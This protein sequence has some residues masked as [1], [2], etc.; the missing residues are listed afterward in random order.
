MIFLIVNLKFQTRYSS[1]IYNISHNL[2]IYTI[3]VHYFKF[4]I[5]NK[6]KNIFCDTYKDGYLKFILN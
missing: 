5:T 4:Q 3:L 1:I 2:K 6:L